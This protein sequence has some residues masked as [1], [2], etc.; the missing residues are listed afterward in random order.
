MARQ[1]LSPMYY[2]Y[3]LY[4]MLYTYYKHYLYSLYYY[5]K[6]HHL[7][8]NLMANHDKPADISS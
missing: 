8:H 6:N 3:Y 4:Y 7:A 1:V 5:N 2:L